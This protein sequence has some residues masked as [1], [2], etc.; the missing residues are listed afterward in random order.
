MRGIK[1]CGQRWPGPH[2][3][4]PLAPSSLSLRAL[5]EH[6][7]WWEVSERRAG[8]WDYPQ[9]PGVTARQSFPSIHTHTPTPKG[10]GA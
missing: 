3:P 9:V 6:P 4:S 8:A 5:E 2:P 10:T 1:Q 7:G